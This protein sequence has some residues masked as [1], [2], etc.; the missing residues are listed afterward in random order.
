MVQAICQYLRAKAS[1][2][3]AERSP[4]Y[5][6]ETSPET[7]YWCLKTMLVVGPDNDSVC[8]EDCGP[9]KGCFELG[10]QAYY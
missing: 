6:T 9:D 1:Y 4:L 5:L 3:P 8:T 10:G 2:V 7:Q